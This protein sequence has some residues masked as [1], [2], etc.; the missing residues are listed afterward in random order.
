M[1]SL[2]ICRPLGTWALAVCWQTWVP[3]F[4]G[5]TVFKL[6][7]LIHLPAVQSMHGERR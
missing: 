2:M 7:V 3:A 1:N 6:V 4:A 5:M